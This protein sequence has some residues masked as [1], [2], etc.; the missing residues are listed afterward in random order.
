L[1]HRLQQGQDFE[2]DQDVVHR[3]LMLGVDTARNGQGGAWAVPI[4]QRSAAWG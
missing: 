3:A 2:I 1:F 4:L